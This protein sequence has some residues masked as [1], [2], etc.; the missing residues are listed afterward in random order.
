M[1]T[2][3][4]DAA[5]PPIRSPLKS[6]GTTVGSSSLGTIITGSTGTSSTGSSGTRSSDSA[7]SSLTRA[8]PARASDPPASDVSAA[9]VVPGASQVGNTNAATT[10]SRPPSTIT[11]LHVLSPSHLRLT[12]PH[13]A[14]TN[15]AKR[16]RREPTNLQRRYAYPS[17]LNRAV[18]PDLI[19]ITLERLVRHA[20]GQ[21]RTQHIRDMSS[22]SPRA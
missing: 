1:S 14:T 15:Q 22:G 13:R 6:A 19:R 2:T 8:P 12:Q 17:S 16:A 20:S 18:R 11:S 4:E 10:T 7:E 3:S 21:K 5:T 9:A